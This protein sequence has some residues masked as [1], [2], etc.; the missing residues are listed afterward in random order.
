MAKDK[1]IFCIK[2]RHYIRPN[3]M[4][5]IPERCG[6]PLNKVTTIKVTHVMEYKNY[7]YLSNPK[8]MNGNNNCRYF[9]KFSLYP[10]ITGCV[11]IF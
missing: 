11:K 3:R 1:R 6:H 10:R 2:C 5:K 4:G 9:K 8:S 7:H